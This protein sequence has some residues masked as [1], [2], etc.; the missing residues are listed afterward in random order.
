MRVGL[1]GTGRIGGNLA[2]LLVAGGDEVVLSAGNPDGPRRLAEELGARATT[3]SPR[4]AIAAVDV[5]A[6]AVWWEAF[7]DIALD[8]GEALQGKI[9][10]D[11]SNPITERAG[12][13]VPLPIPD[14]LTSPQFQLQR[15]G[16]V[17]LVRTF[18]DRFAADLLA[19]GQ[20]GQRTGERSPMR[21]WSDDPAAAD[22]VVALIRDAGFD[23]I[24]GGGLADS[25]NAG[26]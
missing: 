1:I 8:Y 9:V 10:I 13:I 15:L 20:R 6:I 4:D 16:N 2:R 26:E 19:D 24:D 12:Q 17:R 21:Y 14:G 23:P 25:K 5:V 18:G 11:P 22:V 7:P 3:M